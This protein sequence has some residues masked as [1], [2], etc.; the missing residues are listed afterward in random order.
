LHGR[1]LFEAARMGLAAAAITV[2][3]P[4]AAAPELTPDLL[5]ERLARNE[6]ARS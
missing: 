2:E 5:R 4:Q 6:H 1:S 3:S